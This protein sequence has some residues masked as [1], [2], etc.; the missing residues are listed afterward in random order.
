[1]ML[2]AHAATTAH[3]APAAACGASGWHGVYHAKSGKDTVWLE[4]NRACRSV[5]AHL[6]SA[7][8]NHKWEIWV[9]NNKN[10]SSS[11]AF[12]PERITPALNDKG[13]R[14]HA[15]VQEAGQKKN[16]TPYY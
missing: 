10:T 16:C 3:A 11:V 12:S 5:R 1:M 14:S 15:C 2:P 4:Y 13:I 7:D 6:T 9:I 8:T